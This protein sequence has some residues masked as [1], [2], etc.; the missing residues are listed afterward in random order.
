MP[1]DRPVRPDHSKLINAL[2]GPAALS[3]IVVERLGTAIRISPTAV[4]HW[5]FRGIPHRHRVAIA[6][7]AA[8]EGIEIPENFLTGR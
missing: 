7:F 5:R 1:Q 6:R 8:A 3:R 2:G 4:S